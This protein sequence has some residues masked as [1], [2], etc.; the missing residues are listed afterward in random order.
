M[1][2]LIDNYDSFTYN[3][4][5]QVCSLGGEVKVIK[6][7]ELSLAQI[8]ALKPSKIIISPGPKTPT[9]TGVSIPVIKAF[10]QNTPLLGVCLGHQCLAVAFGQEII[11]AQQ[12]IF[13]KTTPVTQSSSRILQGLTQTFEAARY[14]SL[15]IN[16]APK[17]FIVTSR[18]ALGD[19]MSIEHQSLPIFGLQFHPESF[20][21]DSTGDLIIRNFLD[22]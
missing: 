19:I 2:L 12:L 4:Y 3:L 10:F 9:D 17:D 7:D 18:D 14:H 16:D 11:A 15:V 20:L 21:M 5:Q 8:Q 22:I 1:I 6:N 13:G